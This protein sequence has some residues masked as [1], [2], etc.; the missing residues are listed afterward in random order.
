MA[1]TGTLGQ[2]YTAADGDKRGKESSH[3]WLRRDTGQPKTAAD[4]DSRDKEGSQKWLR[5]EDGNRQ[6]N[7]AAY[8]DWAVRVPSAVW[9]VRVEP[10]GT[11]A[12]DLM[13][14]PSRRV[15]EKPRLRMLSG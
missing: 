6:P 15:M 12:A 11:E 7:L 5:T 14:W 1:A 4:E 2:P 13:A 8:F 3:R 9:M 10:G